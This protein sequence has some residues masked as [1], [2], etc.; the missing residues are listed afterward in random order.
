MSKISTSARIA[1]VYQWFPKRAVPY[2]WGKVVAL[3]GRESGRAA[4]EWCNSG[5]FVSLFTIEVTLNR[6]LRNWYQLIKPIRNIENLLT[7]ITKCGKF[8]LL[9]LSSLVGPAYRYSEESF[10][11]GTTG[12][13]GV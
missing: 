1:I 7:L 8:I 6:T 10:L 12:D 13:T 3:R 2:P 5:C 9:L 4:L 11:Y